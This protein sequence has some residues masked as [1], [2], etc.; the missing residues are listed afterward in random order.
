[1]AEQVPLT[2]EENLLR[3]I[4][5]PPDA[6]RAMRPRMRA[7]F[8]WKLSL[9]MLGARYG[10]RSKKLA[11]I[12]SLNMMFAGL[13]L[14]ATV[15]MF[16]DFWFGIPKAEALRRLEEKARAIFVGDLSIEQLKPQA[17]IFLLCPSLHRRSPW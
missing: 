15:F 11:T 8:D 14:L 13:G 10:D 9:K 6:V 4:E 17:I 5:S 7:A 2:P 1:M 16:V 3:I 12:K